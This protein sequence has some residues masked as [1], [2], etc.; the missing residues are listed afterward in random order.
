LYI[1]EVENRSLVYDTLRSQNIF[2]QV[3]YVPVHLHPYYQELGWRTGDFELSE[4]YY[5][6][7]LSIPMYPT[8][9]EQEQ[10]YVIKVLINTCNG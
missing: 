6:K 9:T 4:T 10:D 5:S 7:A 1:I 2:A 8:L 3:H